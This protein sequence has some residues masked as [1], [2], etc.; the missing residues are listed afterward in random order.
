MLF[1]SE[2]EHTNFTV[3]LP[4]DSDAPEFPLGGHNYYNSRDMELLQR[5]LKNWDFGEGS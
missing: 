1:R 3:L 5:S 4:S 2:A